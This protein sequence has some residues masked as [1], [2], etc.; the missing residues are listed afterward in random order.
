ML[1]HR[2]APRQAASDGQRVSTLCPSRHQ[3]SV[4][5]FLYWLTASPFANLPVDPREAYVHPGI[6]I[7]LQVHAAGDGWRHVDPCGVENLPAELVLAPVEVVIVGLLHLRI[8]ASRA[9]EPRAVLPPRPVVVVD[10]PGPGLLDPRLLR[11]PTAAAPDMDPRL[12]AELE[13]L[14]RQGDLTPGVPIVLRGE[15]VAPQPVFVVSG[16][17]VR[18]RGFCGG[19][20]RRSGPNLLLPLVVDPALQTG[21]LIPVYDGLDLPLRPGYGGSD[22]FIVVGGGDLLLYFLPGE[23]LVRGEHALALGEL[24]RQSTILAAGRR[25][26]LIDLSFAQAEASL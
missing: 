1:K 7:L 23:I 25:E 21:A 22:P 2:G 9:F 15:D 24:L 3:R 17:R 5:N 12:A 4:V 11:G 8:A 20:F 18:P 19:V 26:D 16:G 6:L 14:V 13:L 10:V